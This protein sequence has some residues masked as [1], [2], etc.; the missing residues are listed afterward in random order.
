MMLRMG[1]PA[2]SIK[3]EDWLRGEPLADFQPGKVYIV[4]FWATWCE[5]CAAEMLELMQLQEKYKDSGLEV[6]GIAADEDAPTA[7]EARTKLDAWLAEKCPDLNHRIAFDVTGEMKKLWREP[8]FCVGIPTS[9]VVDRD[10]CIAFIGHPSQLGEVLPKVFNGSWPTSNK[11]KAAD[12]QRIATSEP[13]AREQALKKPMDD[14]FWAAVKLE[15]WKTALW[16]IEEGIALMPDDLNFRLAH[17]HLLL[18]K[19]QDMWTGLPVMRQLVRD[20]ID[21]NS[22]DWMVSALDQLFHPANNH[23]RLPPAERFAMGKELSEHI[24]ALNPPQGDSPKFRSY[25]AVARYYHE[26]GNND[27]AIELVELALT[28]RDGPEPIPAELK[29][30]HLRDLLQALAKYRGAQACCGALFAAAQNSFPKV[31]KRG[32]PR[33]KDKKG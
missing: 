3:V 14:R 19:I 4:E 29:E 10:G 31:P 16:A 21:K 5:L 25:P 7:V 2:P 20:A 24:L 28:S 12:Q 22:E 13:L 30:Q 9:F 8:S 33:K 6:V 23:S 15:D 26:N 27:R 18:H 1:S 11:A 32:R 17:A